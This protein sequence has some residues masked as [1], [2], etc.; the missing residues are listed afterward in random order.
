MVYGYDKTQE[1]TF[2]QNLGAQIGGHFFDVLDAQVKASL[3]IT[4]GTKEQ[5]HEETSEQIETQYDA[6]TTY[7]TWKLIDN[8]TLH[9]VTTITGRGWAT[10]RVADNTTTL[11]NVIQIYEDKEPTA[12]I[13]SIGKVV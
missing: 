6:G 3:N 2:A 13:S 12:N 4:E 1:A 5:W 9:R 8:L 11:N 7:L 10:H